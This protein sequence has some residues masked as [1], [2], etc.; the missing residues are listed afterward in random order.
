MNVYQKLGNSL[1][2]V[3]GRGYDIAIP[4]INEMKLD[5]PELIKQGTRYGIKLKAIA[6]AVCLTLVNIES[7]FEPIIG[8]CAQA[9]AL[10]NH[11]LE[12][13]E[14]NP[15]ELWNSEIFGRKL[16]DVIKDGINGKMSD[17]SDNTKQRLQNVMKSL[18]NKSRAN[19][20]AFVF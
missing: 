13:S 7:T 20:I 17:L 18:S 9:E 19:L 16:C 3:N 1:D 6:P 8:S 2:V 15:I 14:N 12:K 4:K 11:M 5:K 10:I